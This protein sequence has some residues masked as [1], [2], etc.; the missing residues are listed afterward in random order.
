MRVA[1]L[2]CVSLY[3]QWVCSLLQQPKSNSGRQLQVAWYVQKQSRARLHHAHTMPPVTVDRCLTWSEAQLPASAA[4]CYG[5]LPS[6]STS[7]DVASV[8][9]AS[10]L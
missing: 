9:P 3:L 6:M 7:Q 5:A 1:S 4:G 2:H 8:S 10:V